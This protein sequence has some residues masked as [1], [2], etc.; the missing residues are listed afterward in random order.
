MGTAHF[1]STAAAIS[2]KEKQS[3]LQRISSIKGLSKVY[4]SPVAGHVVVF[5]CLHPLNFTCYPM[6][7]YFLQ[8]NGRASPDHLLRHECQRIGTFTVTMDAND[9]VLHEYTRGPAR[10]LPVCSELHRTMC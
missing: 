5:F 1:H 4:S 8:H 6:F 7:H 3:R 2:V 10:F 9:F